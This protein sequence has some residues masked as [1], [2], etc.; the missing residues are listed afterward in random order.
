VNRESLIFCVAALVVALAV[1]AAGFRLAALPR[2]VV[3]AAK[4]PAAPETLPDVDLGGGFGRVSV[5]D[6]IGYYIENPP[7]KANAAGGD[8]APAARRFGGC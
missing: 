7:A 1:C 2:D 4:R 5:I 6:L 3:D 8:A